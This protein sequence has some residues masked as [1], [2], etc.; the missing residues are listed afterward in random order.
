[1]TV[2]CS[3]DMCFHPDDGQPCF[4][5]VFLTSEARKIAKDVETPLDVRQSRIED[6]ICSVE[7]SCESCLLKNKLR[8]KIETIKQEARE[9][10]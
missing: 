2:E 7:A 5:D 3:V 4:N 6:V 1:M 9:L 8:E 10:T